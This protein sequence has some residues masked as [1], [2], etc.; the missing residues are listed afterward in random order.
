LEDS[1]TNEM[2]LALQTLLLL[3]LGVLVVLLFMLMLGAL[4]AGVAWSVLS[5]IAW[6][7]RL[8]FR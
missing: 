2:P 7:W 5:F 3:P 8:I 4:A 1:A 6:L